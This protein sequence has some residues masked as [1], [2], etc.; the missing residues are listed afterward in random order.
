MKGIAVCLYL[1]LSLPAAA[2]S[3]GDALCR[4]TSLPVARMDSSE[5][6]CRSFAHALTVLPAETTHEA[7]ALLTPETLAV[8]GTLTAAWMGSQGVPVVGEAVDAALLALGTT[9]LVAETGELVDHHDRP[10]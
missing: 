4:T 8:M 9:L 6:L 10:A 5:K 3:L 1:L 2:N 7:R